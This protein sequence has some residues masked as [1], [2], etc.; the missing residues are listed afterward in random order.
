MEGPLGPQLYWVRAGF[1]Y[2]WTEG[3]LRAG[4]GAL[5]TDQRLAKLELGP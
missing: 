4:H 5:L 3:F 2:R 1:S